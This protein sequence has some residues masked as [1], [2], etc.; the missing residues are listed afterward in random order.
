MVEE[1]DR[2]LAAG[3]TIENGKINGLASTTRS[4][5]DIGLKRFGVSHKP[6]IR[7]FGRKHLH[8]LFILMGNQ[9]LF[10]SQNPEEIV[11]QVYEG[12][13]REWKRLSAASAAGT[14][15]SSSN[16]HFK[17]KDICSKIL[18]KTNS[19]KQDPVACLLIYFLDIIDP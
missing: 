14:T 3:G 16:T 5:G 17:S 4:L 9:N 18:E 8:D 15:D 2:I 19:K 13:Q 1:R 6:G 7:K 10:S 12:I 11:A